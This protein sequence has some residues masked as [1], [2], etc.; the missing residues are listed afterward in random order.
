MGFMERIDK[1]ID[2]KVNTAT[3]TIT[4]SVSEKIDSITSSITNFFLEILLAIISVLAVGA[5][6]YI[7]YYCIK[8]MFFKKEEE[9][10]KILF[11]F[12]VFLL[13]KISGTLIGG[14]MK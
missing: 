1:A 2:D 10:Q 7:F 4:N 5:I 13:L 9:M 8:L 11:G 12:F 3:E 14:V 6:L